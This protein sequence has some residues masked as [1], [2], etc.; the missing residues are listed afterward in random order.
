VDAREKAAAALAAQS[1]GTG[2]QEAKVLFEEQ[3]G[4]CCIC[5]AVA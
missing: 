2:T 1:K 4:I 3:D 5:R